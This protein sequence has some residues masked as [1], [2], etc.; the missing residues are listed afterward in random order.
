MASCLL[1]V[2][3]AR[4]ADDLILNTFAT[5]DEAAQ[6]SRWWGA[7]AQTYEFDATRDAS[8][9]PASGSLKVTVQ[10]DLATHGGDNQFAALRQ[11]NAV[12]GTKYTNLVM[13]LYWDPASPQ[14]PSSG[15]EG[16]RHRAPLH[17]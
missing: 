7:A 11:F 10:F 14:R 16:G 3:T 15:H 2:T 5:A 9:D 8:D 4:G 12:D 17:F 1:A 13:D 6:W